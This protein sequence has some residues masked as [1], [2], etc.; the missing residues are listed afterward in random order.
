M[1]R[2]ERSEIVIALVVPTGTNVTAFDRILKTHLSRFEYNIETY[3]LSEFL[4]EEIY[5]GVQLVDT[6]YAAR[7]QS[8]MSAGN[9]V[10]RKMNRQD[11]LARY[12]VSRIFAKRDVTTPQLS[13]TVH[14]LNS[15]KRPEEVDALRRVYHPGLFI[16]GLNSTEEQR[17][18]NLLAKDCRRTEA[19]ALISRDQDELEEFGQ[20]TRDTF[21]LCDAFVT[22]DDEQ[23]LEQQLCRIVELL[24]GNPFRTPSL[25][26]HA[27]FLA[28]AASLRSADLSRQVGAVILSSRGEVV[29]TGAND[30]PKAGGGQYQAFSAADTTS[31]DDRD[32]V[33]ALDPNAAK[34]EELVSQIVKFA[35]DLSGKTEEETAELAQIQLGSTTLFAITEFGRAVH[36]EMEALITC[37]RTGVSP[38]GGTLYSTT[39]PCHN[40]AKHIVDAGIKRVVFVE[41][42]PKSQALQLH[43]DSVVLGPV[44]N[45][46]EE[47]RV[48][49]EP[50]VGISARHYFDLFSLTLSSG[51][52]LKRK[53]PKSTEKA[54]WPGT[55]VAPR[56]GIPI[57]SYIE[58]EIETAGELNNFVASLSNGTTTVSR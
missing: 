27:M 39:F 35:S 5:H 47:K 58:R 44:S 50:F 53:K 37:A 33:R 31:D 51:Y 52:P 2:I 13:N 36:A 16:L 8:L 46:S 25:D 18:A 21:E 40:C 24:F 56:L 3:K 38:V 30:V 55:N 4:K 43:S 20:R 28:Y 1:T 54:D 45:L 12:A 22:V 10:R 34:R 14:V 17:I 49:F 7:T 11:A 29:A 42:Y 48:I 15:L 41:P 57:N 9:V 23:A 19:E 32:Y 26:E 6:P